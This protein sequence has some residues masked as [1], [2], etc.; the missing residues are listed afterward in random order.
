MDK[1]NDEQTENQSPRTRELET[2]IAVANTMVWIK[3]I[4]EM[5]DRVRKAAFD[6]LPGIKWENT[7]GR[8]TLYSEDRYYFLQRLSPE[9]ISLHKFFIF[10]VW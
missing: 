9:L 7:Y 2:P 4:V 6:H 10:T 5:A 8:F 3:S 1:G